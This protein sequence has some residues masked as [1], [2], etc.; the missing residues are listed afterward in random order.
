MTVAVLLVAAGIGGFYYFADQSDLVRVLMV[1]AGFV[2]GAALAVRTEPG[3]AAWEFTKGARVEARKV[4]WPTRRETTQTTIMVIV[5]VVV[6]GFFIWLVDLGLSLTIKSL[7]VG[8][9]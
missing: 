8:T 9:G 3:R 7:I 5:L 6:V 4:V 2:V 1:L